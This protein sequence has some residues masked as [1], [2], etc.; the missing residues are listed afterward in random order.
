[1][2]VEGGMNV[3]AGSIWQHK[4][5]DG[6][7]MLLPSVDIAAPL[8][9]QLAHAASHAWGKNALRPNQDAPRL[10]IIEWRLSPSAIL[11]NSKH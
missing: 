5:G 6:V 1:M 3:G 2:K 4:W 8:A 11:T 7:H 10:S 9:A